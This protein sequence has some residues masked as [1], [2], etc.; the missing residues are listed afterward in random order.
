MLDACSV[1][2]V[3]GDAGERVSRNGIWKERRDE[4]GHVCKE[5]GRK[6]NVKKLNSNKSEVSLAVSLAHFPFHSHKAW[7]ALYSDP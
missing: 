4:I 6:Q 2:S 5:E 3:S 1:Q 7:L